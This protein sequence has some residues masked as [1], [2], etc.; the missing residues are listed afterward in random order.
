VERLLHDAYTNSLKRAVENNCESIAF[1]L[2]SSGIYGYPKVEALR[3]ATNAIQDFLDAIGR[4][5][6][7]IGN[8]R[9]NRGRHTS[10]IGKY[11]TETKKYQRGDM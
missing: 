9:S 6:H 5:I 1:P 8:A 10:S 11:L 2:I 7:K 3:V 4:T